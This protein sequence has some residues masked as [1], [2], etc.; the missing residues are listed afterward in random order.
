M[1]KYLLKIFKSLVL[2]YA[3]VLGSQ[4]LNA[5][6][7]F[8]K[9]DHCLAYQTKETIFLFI[10]SVVIGKTCEISSEI[11][12]EEGNTRFVLSFPISS[13]DSGV[14]MRDDDVTEMLS[15]DSTND[16]RFI[17]DFITIEQVKS[18][19]V[20]GNTKLGGILEIAGNSYNVLFPLNL[21]E[22]SGK[23]LVKGKLVTSLSEFGLEL[24]SVLGGVVADTYDY[25]ELHVYLNFKITK[26]LPEFQ[27][28]NV[29]HN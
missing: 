9:G 27:S 12:I 25:L 1:N 2:I 11:E 18:A 23:W 17:S 26:G 6:E 14:D 19:L 29:S 20:K 7:I 10:D 4:K 13:L 22:S 15:D 28:A 8:K 16:I 24:P 5:E 3:L 21:S